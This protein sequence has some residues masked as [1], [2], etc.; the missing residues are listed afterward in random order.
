MTKP[1]HRPFEG[2]FNDD[3]LRESIRRAGRASSTSTSRPS[4]NALY[5]YL[6]GTA[7][8]T[9]IAEVQAAMSESADF[10]REYLELAESYA[11]LP[12]ELTREKVERDNVSVFQRV[13]QALSTTVLQPAPAL[14]YLAALVVAGVVIATMMG[15]PSGSPVASI[16]KTAPVVEV[17][18][19]ATL[20]GGDRSVHLAPGAAVRFTLPIPVVDAQ[21]DFKFEIQTGGHTTWS[22]RIP[23]GEVAKLVVQGNVVLLVP[24]SAIATGA[25]T[26]QYGFEG[27]AEDVVRKEV[28]FTR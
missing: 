1:T 26:I 25:V 18:G 20:A 27:S 16:G 5:A 14:S 4:D 22:T 28:T 21:R 8:A 3:T 2:D 23:A 17:S 6:A 15:R 10:R 9:E 13:W 19:S 12:V 11:E 24:E 7:S